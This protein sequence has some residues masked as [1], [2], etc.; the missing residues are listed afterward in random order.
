MPLRREADTTDV[1]KPKK[2]ICKRSPIV[3]NNILP[4]TPQQHTPRTIRIMTRKYSVATQTWPSLKPIMAALRAPKN[5]I[6]HNEAPKT[7]ENQ[8]RDTVST[9]NKYKRKHPN[10]D[11]MDSEGTK[12]ALTEGK[13]TKTMNRSLPATPKS[14]MT[15]KSG[16]FDHATTKRSES[17]VFRANAAP[18][19]PFQ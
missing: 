9:P 15:S 10:T 13:C 6:M 16:R 7:E 1:I 5:S 17:P 8:S 4:T 19:R 11:A 14:F 2:I 18:S 3:V 12:S